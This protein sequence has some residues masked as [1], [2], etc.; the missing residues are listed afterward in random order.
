MCNCACGGAGSGSSNNVLVT[1]HG[2]YLQARQAKHRGAVAQGGCSTGYLQAWQTKHWEAVA[3]G[4]CSTAYLQARQ[5]E[6]K[7]RRPGPR[8]HVLPLEK[9]G[10]TGAC[11]E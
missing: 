11:V 8:G 6:R 9:Q 3:Q 4:G 10:T 7:A 1:A 5:K 2:A